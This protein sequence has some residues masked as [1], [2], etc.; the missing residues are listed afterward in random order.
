MFLAVSVKKVKLKIRATLY[1]R[2]IR[3]INVYIS[4]YIVIIITIIITSINLNI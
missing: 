4:K 3:K 1:T 2:K